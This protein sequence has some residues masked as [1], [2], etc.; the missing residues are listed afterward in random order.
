MCC[1][2]PAAPPT[3]AQHPGSCLYPLRPASLGAC[4]DISRVLIE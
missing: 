4:R 2:I 1:Q 3:V